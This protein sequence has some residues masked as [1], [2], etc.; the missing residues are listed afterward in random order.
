MNVNVKID[1]FNFFFSGVYKTDVYNS[2]NINYFVPSS[3]KFEVHHNF[4]AKLLIREF[5][6]KRN[7]VQIFYVS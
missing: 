1:E 7:I 4:I 3:V 2:T 5:H 6:K